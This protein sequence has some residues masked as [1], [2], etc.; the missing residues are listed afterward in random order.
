M[1]PVNEYFEG[2]VKSIGF[3][4]AAGRATVGV[5]APGDYEFGTASVEIMTV[6][7]GTLTVRLPGR[8]DWQ[9]FS[10][11]ESFEVGRG[12]TFQLKIEADASYLCLYR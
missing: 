3:Q 7:S 12:E 4:T 5:M 2:K 11:G 8:A 10:A 1:F 9:S 6:T